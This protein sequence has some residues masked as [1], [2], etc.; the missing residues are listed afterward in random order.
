[1]SRDRRA[2]DKELQAAAERASE[3]VTYL[4]PP[5]HSNLGSLSLSNNLLSACGARALLT[6]I[7]T[8]FLLL[9]LNVADNAIPRDT[10]QQLSDAVAQNMSARVA[11]VKAQLALG[12]HPRVG[13]HSSVRVL[14]AGLESDSTPVNLVSLLGPVWEYL[15]PV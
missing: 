7:Q 14:A 4:S 15:G 9:S 13:C 5:S 6:A 1:V 11:V 8:H 12:L 3:I 10:Q 2:K